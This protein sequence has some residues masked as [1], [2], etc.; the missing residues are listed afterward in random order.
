VQTGRP[1]RVLNGLAD[2]VNGGFAERVR[3]DAAARMLVLL[4]RAFDL[5]RRGELPSPRA[6]GMAELESLL[7][8]WSPDTL[9]AA[10]YVEDMRPEQLRVLTQRAPAW[11]AALLRHTVRG[12]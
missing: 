5:S 3:L 1:D 11:A 8:G 7:R 2:L 12:A 4:R 6:E 9:T 10:E